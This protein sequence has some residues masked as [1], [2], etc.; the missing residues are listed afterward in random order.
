MGLLIISSFGLFFRTNTDC[1]MINDHSRGLQINASNLNLSEI[2]HGFFTENNGQWDPNFY[3][4]ATTSFGQIGLGKKCVYYNLREFEKG[5]ENNRKLIVDRAMNCNRDKTIET[6]G[7]VV[8]LNFI[9]AEDMK[10]R[11]LE[12]LLHKCNYI[13]GNDPSTWVTGVMNYRKIIYEN[14]WDGIDLVYYFNENCLKYDFIMHP[15]VAPERIRIRIEGIISISVEKNELNIQTPVGMEIKDSNLKI[16]Y[17]DG[18]KSD[19]NGNFKLLGENIYSFELDE[20]DSEREIVIDPL[21]FSTFIDGGDMDFTNDAVF[22]SNNNAYIT[23]YTTSNNFPT[24]PGAYDTSYNGSADVIV[25]KLND[26]GSNLIFSTYIGGS[27]N[28]FGLGIALDTADNPYITGYTESID[29][30]ITSNAFN[31]SLYEEDGFVLK[32]NSAGSGL[33]YSTFLGGTKSDTA[34]CIYVDIYGNTYV[35]GIT[36]SSDFPTTANVFDTSYAG[37]GDGF[38]IKLN[39]SGSGL[40]FSTFIGGWELESIYSITLDSLNNIYVTGYTSSHNFPITIEAYDES[41]NGGFDVFVTKMCSNGSSLLFST[42]IGARSGEYGNDLEIDSYGN[43]YVTGKTAST[44]FPTTNDTYGQS[45]FGGY[46]VFIIKLNP[47]GS[48]LI[49]S[50]FVGGRDSD[51]GEGIAV[52]GEGNVYVTGRTEASDFPIIHGVHDSSLNGSDDAFVFQL[53]SNGSELL[54]SSYIGGKNCEFGKELMIDI[55]GNVIIVGG[56]DSSDFPISVGAY[57]DSLRNGYWGIFV[58]K[59][60]L[61]LPPSAPQNLKVNSGNNFVELNWFPP[62]D[63]GG[64]AIDGYNIYRG[65]TSSNYIL[66]K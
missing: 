43:V 33:I 51:S 29:F 54:Y 28:D 52:D 60:S 10:P 18:M 13:Y 5:Q 12:P 7:H 47:S 45:H 24:M 15:V 66:L 63:D 31:T 6:K 53:N 38:I 39:S 1:E 48:E 14:L 46:D 4:I 20:F 9:D 41:Y 3:F 64:C 34:N 11:G 37:D 27:D 8:K 50:T 58:L 55:N 21:L 61:L 49:F 44:K 36:Y 2:S 17:N 62:A 57:D 42:F 23:G 16:F 22:D 40:L 56:T 32:L 30:P 65:N 59:L 26:I 19:I 25:I 35:G